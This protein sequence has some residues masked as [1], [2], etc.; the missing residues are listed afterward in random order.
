MRVVVEHGLRKLVVMGL[1]GV[2]DQMMSSRRDQ[3]ICVTT[4]P[5]RRADALC[6]YTALTARRHC[7]DPCASRQHHA[8]VRVLPHIKGLDD[9]FGHFL[10]CV[11]CPCGAVRE[12]EPEALARLVG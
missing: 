8:P 3:C 2:V 11:V 10:V 1:C 6:T 4:V 5:R 12:I 7:V 9:C